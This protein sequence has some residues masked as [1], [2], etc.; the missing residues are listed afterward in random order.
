M[1]GLLASVACTGRAAGPP[2]STR[3]GSTGRVE[4]AEFSPA[5]L[6][7]RAAHSATL[8]ADAPSPPNR[9]SP[10]RRDSAAAPARPR[11]D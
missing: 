8:L 6:R 3:E 10:A 4:T 9:R 11:P 5:P 7:S 1:L 2:E